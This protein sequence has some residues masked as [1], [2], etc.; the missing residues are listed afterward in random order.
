MA[1][2]G[3]SEKLQSTF[4]KLRGKGKLNEKDIKEAMREVKLALLEADVNYKVVK[5]FVSNVSSKCVGGDVLESLTPGQQVIKIVNE[6]LTNLMGG[7][8]SK[9]NYSSYGPTVIMLVGLQG[10]GKTTMCGK[11]ALQ[12]RKDNK[13]PLLVAC[14]IYRPAAIKQLQVVGK[15]I[16]I[17]VFTMGDKVSPV[18]I[19]KA[20]IKQGRNDGNNVII[21]D[22][23]GRL[24]IDEE[25]MQELKDVKSAVEP[26][27]ILLVVDSMTGQDAV[28]VAESF[29]KELDVSGVILT[30]LD[31]DTRGGAALS[32]RSITEK[33]IKYIGVGEKMSDFEVF[34]PERMASRILGMG[35]VLSLIEKAQEAIDEK[36]AG[37]L[38]KKMMTNELNFEDFLTAMEQMKKL[39]PLNKIMEMIPGMESQNVGKIDFEKSEKQLDK[40][41]AIIQSM[42]LKERRNPSL[43]IGS[44]SRKKRVALGA[45]T[46][47]QEVNK[48]IKGYEAMKKQMKQVKSLTKKS[49]KGLFG[50]MP[51]MS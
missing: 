26:N 47:I 3:L 14:D 32:I 25:L 42:T 29:N 43:L 9:L 24:H 7:S 8:E 21:I 6:E 11:L 36:E 18:D 34:H 16:D 27:E 17:P 51:F 50:K 49:R 44:S 31:G 41:K 30:K 15:Q 37:D 22:T 13:K 20:A 39:G 46:T 28:N 4:K 45:G 35:D 1:F 48:L 40:T 10:A 19:A 33:P 23:A 2:E 12:L 38:A 5:T